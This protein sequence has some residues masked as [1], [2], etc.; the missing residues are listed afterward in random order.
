MDSRRFEHLFLL[1]GSN[2]LPN[3]IAAI[4]FCETRH[5]EFGPKSIRFFYTEQTQR[6]RE[7][8]E[9]CLKKRLPGLTFSG[10]SIREATD[11]ASVRTAMAEIPSSCHLHYTG[12][13]KIMAAIARMEFGREHDRDKWASYLDERRGLLLFDDGRK[14][15]LAKESIDLSL[16]LLLELH[17]IERMPPERRVDA[18]SNTQVPTLADTE[19]IAKQVSNASLVGKLS[20]LSKDPGEWEAAW[21]TDEALD[22]QKVFG[23]PIGLDRI[24]LRAWG[25][26]KKN[27]SQGRKSPYKRWIRFVRGGWLEDLIADRL[28]KGL[29]D[30]EVATNV[31]CKLPTDRSFEIDIAVVKGHRLHLLSCTTDATIPRCKQKLFEAATRARQMGGDLARPA[32]ACLVH[33]KG[34]KALSIDSLRSDVETIWLAPNRPEV[35]GLEDLRRVMA[36]EDLKQSGPLWQWLQEEPG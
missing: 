25:D 26:V 10:K 4:V 36:G 31:V 1:V 24:P 23:V 5:S 8:L 17:G 28:R 29:P 20:E 11:A 32:L 6:V 34:S 3:Y 33:G 7:N 19:A 13:T 21:K 18:E 30:A 15:S 9:A 35:F 2:P 16:D 22:L 27:N 12:G 14:L